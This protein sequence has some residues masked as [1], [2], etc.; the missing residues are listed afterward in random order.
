VLTRELDVVTE[1]PTRPAN[2]VFLY[3]PKLWLGMLEFHRPDQAQL[4]ML[5]RTRCALEGS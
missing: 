5:E 4:Q 3:V 1:L 2:E